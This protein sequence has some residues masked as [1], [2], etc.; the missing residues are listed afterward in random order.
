M[1]AL[2]NDRLA[3]L[4]APFCFDHLIRSARGRSPAAGH[5]YQRPDRDHPELDLGVRLGVMLRCFVGVIFGM[6]G[7][8]SSSVSVMRGG[9]VIIILMMLRSFGVMLGRL[10]VVLSSLLVVGRS[11][12]VRHFN[13]HFSRSLADVPAEAIDGAGAVDRHP[14]ARTVRRTCDDGR[15][16][17]P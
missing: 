17:A 11:F 4:G 14:S 5:E 15:R 7:M 12:M 10:F 6:S 13:L 1:T 2:L 9:F 3:E 16:G 8:T